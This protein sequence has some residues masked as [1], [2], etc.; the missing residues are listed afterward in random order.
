MTKLIPA[1]ATH[2]LLAAR[3]ILL[4]L[5]LLLALFPAAGWS[6]Y[7]PAARRPFGDSLAKVHAERVRSYDLQHIR[8]DLRLDERIQSVAGTSTLVLRPLQ[9]GLETVEVDSAELRIQSVTFPD[10]TPLPFEEAGETLRIRLPR[11][12]GPDDLLT[13]TIAYD[14]KPRKGLYF[15]QPDR[16]YPKRHPQIWSQGEMDDSHFWFPVYDYPNDR[17]TSEGFYT[18]NSSFTVISNGRLLGVTENTQLRTK[19]YHWKQEVPHS[20]YLVSVVAGEFEKYTERAGDVPLE[21][22]VPPGTGREK[23][24]RSFSE[25]P[26]ALRFFT[27]RIGLPYPYAKYSQ[28]TV[29]EFTFGG[30]ENISA[31]TLNDRTL[32]EADSEPQSSSVDLVAHELAH[33]WF[34]DLLTCRNWAHLWLNEGFATFW[35]ALY[36]E[37]RYGREEYLN[38]VREDRGRYLDEDRQRYRRPLVTSYYSDPVD[39]FDR[40]TYQKGFLVLDMLRYLL[41][42]ERFFRAMAHYARTYRNQTV[43]TDD[44]QKAVEEASGE[45]LGWFFEQWVRQAGYPELSVSQ[46]WDESARQA[47]LVIQQTQALDE[48]TPLFRMP[49]DVEFTTPGGTKAVRIEFS[50]QREEYTFD[51]DAKPLMT[52]FDP[53]G[54]V[55]MTVQFH[56]PAAE[57]LYQLE[58]DPSIVGRIW[59]A[60]QLASAS[61]DRTEI[62]RA[63]RERLLRDSFW[64]VREAAAGALGEMKTAEAREALAAG[65]QDRNPEVRQ[66]VARAL[67]GFFKDQQADRLVRRLFESDRNPTTAAEAAYSVARIQ[68]RGAREF[69]ERALR[70]ESDHDV[71]RRFALAGLRE[72]GDKRS[73]DLAAQWSRYGHPSQTRIVAIEALSRLGAR[74]EKTADM[75]IALLEDPN[76][77]VRQRAIR[78]LGEGGFQKGRSA[79]NRLAQSEVHSETRRAVQRAL[80]LLGVPTRADAFSAPAPPR[81]FVRSLLTSSPPARSQSAAPSLVP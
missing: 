49:V 21:Y 60:E 6:Q 63:L 7:V 5:S 1:S 22:Y 32:H 41:G 62:A 68:G 39:L 14:G 20:T 50:R 12:A 79:L 31:T 19:T 23:A 71:I 29:Q 10:G 34:G 3:R 74:E 38:E 51:L 52:R 33:Q 48:M 76:V 42:D 65:L 72:L 25:T 80:E 4:G 67:G 64:A 56:K 70:R 8:L 47:R 45:N 43:V 36:R 11:P 26:A 73:W 2:K 15:F 69:L 30:M 54:R 57:L 59:A 24:L 27:G 81:E 16:S 61:G 55:L 13:L 53:D 40:T 46:E 28:T 77:F 9:A 44:F 17:T 35:A 18:V 66:A 78:A 75:L 58:H 37:H